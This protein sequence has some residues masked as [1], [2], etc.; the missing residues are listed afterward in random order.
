MT[1]TPDS[2]TGRAPAGLDGASR[3]LA[4]CFWT[5]FV[6]TVL[7]AAS[8]VAVTASSQVLSSLCGSSCHSGYVIDATLGR[9]VAMGEPTL[10]LASMVGWALARRTPRT[11]G[12]AVYSVVLA[13]QLALTSWILLAAYHL[14][15]G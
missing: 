15:T 14:F 10:A 3:F 12:T 5:A 2:F 1:T 13:I 7:I 11:A 9:I 8:L 4:V 6:I